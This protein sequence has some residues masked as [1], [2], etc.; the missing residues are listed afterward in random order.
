MGLLRQAA[1]R[2]RARDE[3]DFISVPRKTPEQLEKDAQ[4]R[5][6]REMKYKERL[7]TKIR[8]A[9]LYTSECEHYETH[10][11]ESILEDNS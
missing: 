9:G 11:L 7:L 2:D 4:D 6:E 8:E 3:P 1:E 5:K 10:E